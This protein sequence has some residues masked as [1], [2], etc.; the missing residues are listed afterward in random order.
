[1]DAVLKCA[2]TVVQEMGKL[3][4]ENQ[5]MILGHLWKPHYPKRSF[6]ERERCGM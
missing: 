6:R 5:I 3:P 2:T 4:I 1:M